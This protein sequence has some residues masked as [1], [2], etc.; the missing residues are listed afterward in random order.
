M[1][2][3]A[4]RL[5][6][7]LRVGMNPGAECDARLNQHHEC[8]AGSWHHSHG[9]STGAGAATARKMLI[10]HPEWCKFQLSHR[11]TD[12]K[13]GGNHPHEHGSILGDATGQ[14]MC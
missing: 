1:E 13:R 8:A 2:S 5:A 4:V 12:E 3:G 11:E 10:E 7:R 14:L 6:V 9:E